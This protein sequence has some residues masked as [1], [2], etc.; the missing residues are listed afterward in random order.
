MQSDVKAIAAGTSLEEA[1]RDQVVIIEGSYY[2]PPASLTI[3]TLRPSTTPYV[4]P[5]KGDA[6][7]FDVVA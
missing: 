7:Y 3:G 5:W 1:P 2:F 6:K 4:C